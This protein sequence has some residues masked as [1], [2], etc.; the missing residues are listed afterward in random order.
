MLSLKY[1]YFFPLLF[2]FNLVQLS[3]S[4]N[5]FILHPMKNKFLQLILIISLDFAS[6]ELHLYSSRTYGPM[7]ISKLTPAPGNRT[8]HLM[9]GRPTLYLTTTDTSSC[10]VEGHLEFSP[11]TF[12]SITL[13]SIS[14]F[15]TMFSLPNPSVEIGFICRPEIFGILTTLKFYCSLKN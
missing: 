3:L 8:R 7:K 10:S 1:R 15:P 5:I 14:P 13:P 6:W 2:H 9:I 11:L 12:T 4:L